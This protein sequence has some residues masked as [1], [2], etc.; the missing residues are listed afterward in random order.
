MIWASGVQRA[1]RQEA[2]DRDINATDRVRQILGLAVTRKPQRLRLSVSLAEED[3]A[4]LAER[5]ELDP[6]DRLA[7]KQRAA[8]AIV[9]HVATSGVGAQ[10]A[11][12]AE[13]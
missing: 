6:N 8:E 5:F 10:T 1:I 2:L 9:E 13:S 7:I 3:F 11:T 12:D 4:V